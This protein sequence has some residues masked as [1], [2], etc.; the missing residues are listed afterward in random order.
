M[1]FDPEKSDH[2]NMGLEHARKFL[3]PIKARFPSIS[4]ADLW[5]FVGKVSV[6]EMGGPRIAW[7][8]GRVDFDPKQI[9]KDPVL[10][11]KIP[12]HGRLPKAHLGTSHLRQVWFRMGFGDREIVALVGSHSVGRCHEERSGF[13]GPW[14]LT[15]T[16]FN[17]QFFIELL[18]NTWVP[19]KWTGA[20]QMTDPTD[21]LMML[22]TDMAFLYDPAFRSV[23]EEYANDND[24]FFTDFAAA[25]ARL[26]ELGVPRSASNPGPFIPNGPAPLS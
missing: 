21:R 4:L 23:V 12:P 15:P 2:D 10:R 3:E 9:E 1:R 19:K 14:T 24:L 16:R 26:L 7:K 5:T 17:N 25:F 11:A 8:P 6:E 20:F 18:K 13:T 22:P